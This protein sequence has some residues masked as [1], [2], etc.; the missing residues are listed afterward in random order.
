M[1]PCTPCARGREKG[2]GGT[3]VLVDEGDEDAD[4]GVEHG[5][6]GNGDSRRAD[7]GERIGSAGRG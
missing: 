4:D 6:Q 2:G 7:H 5:H 3:A 1:L